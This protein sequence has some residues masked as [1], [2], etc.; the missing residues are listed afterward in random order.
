MTSRCILNDILT[1]RRAGQPRPY[2]GIAYL[3]VRSVR[4]VHARKRWAGAVDPG[5][6]PRP[7]Q[8]V[9]LSPDEGAAKRQNANLRG[10]PSQSRRTLE[11]I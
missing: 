7:C 10:Y 1:V 2:R 5:R 8:L 4:Q 3:L 6:T 9:P 11:V